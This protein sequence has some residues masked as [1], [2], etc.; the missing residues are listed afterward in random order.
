M[1]SAERMQQTA[2]CRFD[3]WTRMFPVLASLHISL[4]DGPITLV[5]AL[6]EA[7]LPCESEAQRV[8]RALGQFS[9]QVESLT[10]P[11]ASNPWLG[12]RVVAGPQC[13]WLR[14]EPSQ[15]LRLRQVER[16]R[17]PA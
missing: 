6:H 4:D 13:W 2:N 3:S 17:P 5:D 16:L 1:T 8:L 15:R 11:F 9:W 10:G 7:P 12:F 14:F